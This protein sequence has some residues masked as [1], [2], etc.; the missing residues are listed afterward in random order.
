MI[1]LMAV[2][3]IS[4][5]NSKSARRNHFE[6]QH[7]AKSRELGVSLPSRLALVERSAPKFSK[8]LNGDDGLVAVHARA[9]FIMSV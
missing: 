3:R 9:E 2:S 5:K 4:S 6:Q 7:E 8:D 1:F